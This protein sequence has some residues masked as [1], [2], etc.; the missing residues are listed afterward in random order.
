MK[1]YPVYTLN[2]FRLVPKSFEE[3]VIALTNNTLKYRKENGITR[4]DF[5]DAISRTPSIS[6]I[7]IAAHM[8]NLIIDGFESTSTVNIN[9][10]MDL[11]L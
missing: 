6:L 2:V 9:V 8:A 5:L 10:K 4:N 11:C 1:E 3:G 7:E